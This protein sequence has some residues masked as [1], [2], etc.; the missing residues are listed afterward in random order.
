M[1]VYVIERKQLLG[2]FNVSK[3]FYG[4]KEKVD[5]AVTFSQRDTITEFDGSSIY[6]ENGNFF[7][8]KNMGPYEVEWGL[9]S[10]C[11][12]RDGNHR[13]DQEILQ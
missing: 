11:L 1:C 5:S 4:M 10:I 9:L 13:W 3:V 8:F 2:P 12:V 7:A 6:L